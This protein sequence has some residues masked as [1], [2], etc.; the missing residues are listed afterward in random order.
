MTTLD[1]ILVITLATG[2]LFVTLNFLVFGL[3]IQVGQLI[4]KF[5]QAWQLALW[6]LLVNYVVFTAIIIGFVLL[7]AAGVP[8]A[9][10]VGFCIIALGAGSPFAPLV[11][12]LAKGDIAT[13][14]TLMVVLTVATIIVVPLALPPVA[15][16]VDPQLRVSNW[17]VAWPILAFMLVPLVI[18]ILARLRWSEVAAEAAHFLRP[19]SIVALLLHVNFYFVANWNAYVAAWNTGT[20]MAAIAVPL[21]GL[22]CA[23]VLVTI[24]RMKDEGTRHACEITTGMRSLPIVILMI[25]FPFVA[26]PFVGVSS[27]M[28][29]CIGLVVLLIFGMEW[30]R[31]V[32]RRS[33]V[34]ESAEETTT[35]QQPLRATST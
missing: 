22:A 7:V 11:T 9:V 18:G 27:L 13:A 15:A 33:S 3:T 28:A 8:P 32:S 34:A 29:N 26:D 30:G 21:L 31:A 24:L 14:L 4:A 17:D 10:K 12:R 5:F 19:V 25:L 6:V 2:V 23:Y 1:P 20:Y 16:A 35:E